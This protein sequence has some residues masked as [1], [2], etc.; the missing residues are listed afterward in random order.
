MLLTVARPRVIAAA[1]AVAALVPVA[2]SL[3]ASGATKA[4]DGLAASL[5]ITRA[6][7][8]AGWST[9]AAPKSVPPITCSAFNPTVRGA[10]QIGAAISPRYQGSSTGP[11]VSQTAYVYATP[12]Q[13]RAVARA[14][15]NAKLGR[16]LASGLVDG[17]GAGVTF[18][19]KAGVPLRLP[20]LGSGVAAVG[21]RVP[22]TASKPYQLVDVYL[23]AIVLARG[24]AITE[25][26][27]A[28]F[29]EPPARSLEL[30]LARQLARLLAA[31]ARS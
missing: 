12:A 22:G 21:Y 15:M 5:L 8:G 11:F 30:R 27:F 16:C 14:Q 19:A 7:L 23:D 1:I 13:G 28:T 4:G 2:P 29:F 31:P 25:V 10:V 3:A 20:G 17:S 18:A 6:E 9:G 26:S 24:S